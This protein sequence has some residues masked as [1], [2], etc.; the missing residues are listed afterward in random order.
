MSTHRILLTGA[1]S[2]IGAATA[3]LLAGDG[4]RLALVARS[5]EGLAA[6][7]RDCPGDHLVL[8]GDLAA[9]GVAESAV[10]A[11]VSAWGGLD[12][13]VANV[14][15]FIPGALAEGD[16]AA[17]EQ[18][19]AANVFTLLRTIRAAVPVLLRQGRGHVVITASVAGRT[20]IPGQVVYC[21]AKHAV[22]AIADGL[23][24]ETRAHGLRVSVVAPGWVANEF[25]D[26]HFPAAELAAK[27]AEGMC[28]G[29]DD[30]ARGI[31]YVLTQPD[32]VDVFDLCI[33]PRLQHH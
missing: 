27:R 31:R 8:P 18:G 2:G 7:R 22:Y 30:I 23:R 13:V 11:C 26:G 16:P 1:S 29:S 5:A 10:A 17:W 32:G 28:L 12:A 9:A 6:V 21:A 25:W 15:A 20:V 3:R 24:R 19:F 14:G 4:A 33:E